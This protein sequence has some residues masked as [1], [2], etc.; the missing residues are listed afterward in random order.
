MKTGGQDGS[1][2]AKGHH[3]IVRFMH[4]FDKYDRFFDTSR[5]GTRLADGKRSPR[6]TYRYKAIVEHNRMLF[7]EVHILDLASH[8]GRWSLAALDAGA[9][10]VVGIEGRY[11]NLASAYRNFAAYEVSPD[12]YSFIHG[13]VPS[14]MDKF[15][16]KSFDLI[17]CLGIFYHTVHHY[18]FFHQFYRLGARHVILDTEIARD[19]GPLVNFRFEDHNADDGQ[20]L[21]STNGLPRSIVGIPSHAMIAMLCDQFQFSWQIVDW[22]AFGI[23]RW[24]GMEDYHADNRRTY[25]LES[26]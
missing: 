24:D 7:P 21:Q 18:D 16:P 26:L 15:E 20:T 2:P 23:E 17:L 3:H 5:I 11:S 10:S 4:F 12:R 19:E 1:L 14:A 25:V 8:D 9:A 22:K 6:L 13:D